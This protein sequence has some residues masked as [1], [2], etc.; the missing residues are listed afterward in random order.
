MD[1]SMILDTVEGLRERACAVSDAI[2]DHPETGRTERFACRQLT[3]L[4]EEEGFQVERGVGGLETSFRA[5]WS[6]GE[7]GPSIG[8]ACEYD[9]LNQLGHGCGHQMQGPA[10]VAAAAALK[11][12]AGAEPFRVVVYG[13][14]DEEYGNGKIEM[15][16][17]G[18]FQDLDFVLMTHLGPNTTVDLKSLAQRIYIAEYHGRAAHAAVKPEA[19]RSA[20]DAMLLSLHGLEML[21]EHVRDDVRMHYSILETSPNSNTVPAYAKIEYNLRANS[22]DYLD[23]V[24]RRFEKVME[25]A[26]I[27]SGTTVDYRVAADCKSKIPMH[28]L[29]GVLMGH[30]R[31]LEAPQMIPFRERTGTT[32][33]GNLMQVVPGANIRVACVPEGTS[34]HSQTV[35]DAGKSPALHDGLVLAAKIMALTG[36]DLICDGEL[37]RR[38]RAEFEQVLAAERREA[39]LE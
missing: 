20:V 2:F 29:T 25:G 38:I 31:E 26:A 35:V 28:V 6:N 22:S 16:E 33:A 18:C 24:C 17:N 7:G 36:A 3:A 12:A 27:M 32:D 4:L 19:G 13:T 10:A 11:A 21:R 39:A 8:F 1:R 9:A 15:L 23:Q 30:A 5:V 37:R 34:L 14:P